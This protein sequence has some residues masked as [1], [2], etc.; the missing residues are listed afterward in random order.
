MMRDI[1]LRR[2][3]RGRQLADRGRLL[4]EREQQPVPQRVPQ[5][6]EL[7]RRRDLEPVRHLLCHESS[8]KSS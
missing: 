8:V 1:A 3:E 6:L 4:P 7:L 2:P 5:R